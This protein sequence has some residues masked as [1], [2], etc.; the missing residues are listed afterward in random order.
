MRPILDR[1]E[2]IMRETQQLYIVTRQT[3]YGNTL[4]AGTEHGICSIQL[5]NDESVLKLMLRR[6]FP[7]A[8]FADGTTQHENWI[9]SVYAFIDGDTTGE[10]PLDIYG[11]PFQKKVWNAL[12]E[13][14]KGE[15][16]SYTEIAAKISSP[17]AVRSVATACANN[18]LAIVIPCHRVVR[19][20]GV[21][22]KY[23]WGVKRK[24]ALLKKE[25][26]FQGR[27]P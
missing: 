14:P 3:D 22:S 5:G 9:N 7:E 13:I 18:K 23:K 25:V 6:D 21:I 8:V 11:T 20:D 26:D 19:K 12:L 10:F 15:V 4:V 17:K 2:L 1:K 27:C 16:C 24:R